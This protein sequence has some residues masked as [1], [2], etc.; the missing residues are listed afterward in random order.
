REL[1]NL[2]ERSVLLS[3]SNM[4]EDIPLPVTKEMQG[5][6]KEQDWYIKTIEE[7]EREHILAVL[8]KCMGRIRG[9]GGAADI[10]GVPPT[11]LASKMKKLGIRREF[12]V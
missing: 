6:I 2:I 1:E 9:P 4:L 7:N 5:A 12:K 8:N 3:K 10:L 11:T